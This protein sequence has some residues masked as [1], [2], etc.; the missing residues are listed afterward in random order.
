MHKSC[1]KLSIT[2]KIKPEF[3]AK[4]TIFETTKSNILHYI[5]FVHCILTVAGMLEKNC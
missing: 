5:L 1:L 2:N 3:H 4:A